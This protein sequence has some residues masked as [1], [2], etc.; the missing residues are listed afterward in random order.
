MY[1]DDCNEHMVLLRGH[2]NEAC[3]RARGDAFVTR[4]QPIGGRLMT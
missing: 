2:I 3:R 4:S 1:F